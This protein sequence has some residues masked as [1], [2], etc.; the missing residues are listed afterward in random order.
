MVRWTIVMGAALIGGAATYFLART[1]SGFM[2]TDAVL[3]AAVVTLGV[4]VIAHMN[5]PQSEDFE[6]SIE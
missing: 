2:P 5:T 4:G 6:D 1:Y 3:C